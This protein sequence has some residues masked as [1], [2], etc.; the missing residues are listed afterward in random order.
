MVSHQLRPL[1][2]IYNKKE[3]VV[4]KWNYKISV[5]HNI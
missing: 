5:D 4:L 2:T 1:A 3:E